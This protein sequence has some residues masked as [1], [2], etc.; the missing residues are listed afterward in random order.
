VLREFTL[1]DDGFILELLNEPGFLRF[2]G[3]KGV[4]TLADAREYLQRGPM[5]SYRQNGFG[6]YAVC[7][8]EAAPLGMCGLVNR[9]GLDDPDI[10]F[11]FLARNWGNGYAVEAAAAVLDHGRRV[12]ALPRILAITSPDNRASISVLEKIGFQFER[13]MQLPR[14]TEPVKLF[15]ATRARESA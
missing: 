14:D 11:A 2:I 6:L 9:Q 4:R 10:G 13:L 8:G 1:E 3:D 12:L 5:D 15:A 7:V